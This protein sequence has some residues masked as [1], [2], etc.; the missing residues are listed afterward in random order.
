MMN[1][2]AEFQMVLDGQQRVQSLLLALRGDSWGFRLLDRDWRE[3]LSGARARGRRGTPHW[4]LGCLCVD[5]K[6]LSLAYAITN[7]ATAIDYSNVMCWVVTDDA[8]GLSQM[9]RPAN[10]R[11]PLPR[12]SQCPARYVRLSRLWD[13]APE[14]ANLDPF[15]ALTI[16]D[17]ILL[18]HGFSEEA[19][20]NLKQPVAA[21]ILALREVKQTRVMFL[22]LAQYEEALG[23]R[24]IYNDAVVSIFTRL[25]TA[26]RT[27]TREDITFAWLKIGWDV[28]C[29]E[30]RDAK[31][32]IERLAA[33]LKDLGVSI[34][35]EDVISAISFIW[36]VSFNSGRLLD[37]TDLIKGEAIRPMASEIS[38]NWSL[39]TESVTH[40]CERAWQRGLRFR[41]HYQSVN[42]LAYLWAWYFVAMR[43]GESQRLSELEKDSLEKRLAS[44]L[45]RLMDRWLVCSQWA[46]V[47]ASGTAQNMKTYGAG[48]AECAVA[49]DEATSGAAVAAVLET[50]LNAEVGGIEQNAIEGFTGLSAHDRQSVRTYYTALWL[51]NRLEQDRWNAAKLVLRHRR[52]QATLE[53]DHIVA[54]GLWDEKVEQLVVAQGELDLVRRIE[55]SLEVNEIGNCTL[56]EKNFNISKSK[57]SLKDFLSEVHEFASGETRVDEWSAAM[58]LGADQVDAAAKPLDILAAAIS[59][60]TLSIQTELQQ[61]IRGAKD[62]V[63]VTTD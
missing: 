24:D 8:N 41:E 1:P 17:Q 55:L 42:S 25:N 16:A 19:R 40:V 20:N 35:T 46:G 9:K 26:G 39:L 60:R 37:N 53:V 43:W 18:T 23:T 56:L 28:S 7:Q 57:R 59:E 22:E 44:S 63:D 32:C 12:T 27:L 11:E 52:T 62:R 29:T 15:A 34:S 21:F 49:L 30:S 45:D 38:K 47:W 2:P 61:F 5:I 50:R 3:Y 54:C 51:W 58:E 6:K 4:S 36:S 14:Q 31:V 48:L 13:A 10:Y 33:E